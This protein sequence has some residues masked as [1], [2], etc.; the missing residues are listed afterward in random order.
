MGSSPSA[1]ARATSAADTSPRSLPSSTTTAAAD[2]P[3]SIFADA[4]WIVVDNA[5]ITG[6]VIASATVRI[7]SG[8]PGRVR[9]SSLERVPP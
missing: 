8:G 9:G 7:G 4:S 1:S 6:S 2:P 3:S 5:T